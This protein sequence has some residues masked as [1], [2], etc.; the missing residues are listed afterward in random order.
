MV[1][2]TIN[3]TNSIFVITHPNTPSTGTKFLQVDELELNHVLSYYSGCGFETIKIMLNLY[4]I[5]TRRDATCF[6]II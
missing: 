4:F 5:I 2:I 1:C 6:S 3:Y